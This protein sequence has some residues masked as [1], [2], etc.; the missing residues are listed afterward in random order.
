MKTKL[1]KVDRVLSCWNDFNRRLDAYIA[2]Q[3]DNE[4]A[5]LDLSSAVT[6][7]MVGLRNW[8]NTNSPGA[9][10]DAVSPLSPRGGFTICIRNWTLP[11]TGPKKKCKNYELPPVEAG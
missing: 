9:P 6:I 11:Q 8:L 10:A 1:V 7:A 3:I 4:G 5:D 2:Q